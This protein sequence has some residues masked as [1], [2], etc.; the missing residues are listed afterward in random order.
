MKRM[1]RRAI[2]A[3]QSA[4]VWAYMMLDLIEAEMR[5]KEDR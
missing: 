4:L 5:D 2:Q 1:T 3:A